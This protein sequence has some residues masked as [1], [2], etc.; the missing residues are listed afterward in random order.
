VA[1][2]CKTVHEIVASIEKVYG[3]KVDFGA[4]GLAGGTEEDACAEG[5]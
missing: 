5:G 4:H 1:A 2:D 3:V